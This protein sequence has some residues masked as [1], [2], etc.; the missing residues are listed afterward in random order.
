MVVVRSVKLFNPT[1]FLDSY[2]VS[3]DGKKIALCLLLEHQKSTLLTLMD[4]WDAELNR[5]GVLYSVKELTLERIVWIR[6]D[7]TRIN[8]YGY[9]NYLSP[10]SPSLPSQLHL[11][12]ANPHSNQGKQLCR[13][14]RRQRMGS[15]GGQGRICHTDP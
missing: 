12:A 8:A 1:V 2:D 4:H 13:P 14:S 11:H 5:H 10:C 15:S 7:Q 6:A 3:H 9:G